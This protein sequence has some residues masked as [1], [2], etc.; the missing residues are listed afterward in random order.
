MTTRKTNHLLSSFFLIALLLTGC[1]ASSPANPSENIP[2]D[3]GRLSLSLTDAGVQGYQAVYVTVDRVQIH[4]NNDS[5][6]NWQTVATP[7]RTYN[8][9]DLT[10][11]VRES[12]G[13]SLLAV[14]AYSQIRVILGS[15]PD[16]SLN[17]LDDEHPYANYVITDDNRIHELH[18]PSAQ[19]SGIKINHS[20]DME[21]GVT[22]ELLL[23]F[24]AARSIVTA[25][26]SGRYILKPVIKVLAMEEAL[27]LEGVVRDARGNRLENVFLQAE[28][29]DRTEFDVKDEVVVHAAALTDNFGNYSLFLPRGTYQLVAYKDGY[30]VSVEQVVINSDSTTQAMTLT[31]AG[32]GFI[33]GNVDTSSSSDDDIVTLSFRQ[34]VDIASSPRQVEVFSVNIENT[35]S[36]AVALPVG[37]YEVVSSSDGE[38]TMVTAVIVEEGVTNILNID[39]EDPILVQ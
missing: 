27:V 11:G 5:D 6:T 12:L 22:R 9:L 15:S 38:M 8:L 29:Y 17:I 25:G 30:A 31:P 33:E 37:T 13:S 32:R 2:P 16:T 39:F 26:N 36:Y 28:T 20:F 4:R 7:N 35:G 23:D 3:S 19:E 18:T 1:D 34:I 24:N 10:N 21:D 14:G